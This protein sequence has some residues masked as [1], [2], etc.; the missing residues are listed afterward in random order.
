MNIEKIKEEIKD[1]LEGCE[2]SIKDYELSNEG[3]NYINQGWIEGLEYAL[4]VIKRNAVAEPPT[5]GDSTQSL[6]FI[7]DKLNAYMRRPLKGDVKHEVTDDE[8]DD[9]CTSMSWIEEEM[10]VRYVNGE[11]IP[12]PAQEDEYD[13][14]K[15]GDGGQQEFVDDLQNRAKTEA[16]KRDL[17]TISD[18]LWEQ[19][20]HTILTHMM[21]L[22]VENEEEIEDMIIYHS[23]SAGEDE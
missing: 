20:D 7:W 14:A 16:L 19:I 1:T 15:D 9:I 4:G 23:D 12:T 18:N 22:V 11:Y 8:R 6:N 3:G 17:Q 2:D 10:G 21:C 13:D 5:H